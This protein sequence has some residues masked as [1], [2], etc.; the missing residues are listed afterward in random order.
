MDVL[1]TRLNDTGLIIL[2][3]FNRQADHSISD[4]TYEAMAAAILELAKHQDG[5][6]EV[7]DI[8]ASLK[9]PWTSRCYYRPEVEEHSETEVSLRGH[10]Y[11]RHFHGYYRVINIAAQ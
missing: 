11:A 5:P 9:N 3:R 7:A 10:G 8:I 1:Q 2:L 4:Q 6:K